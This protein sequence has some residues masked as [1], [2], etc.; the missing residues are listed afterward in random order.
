LLENS[1]YR[2]NWSIENPHIG[3]FAY[4]STTPNSE[5]KFSESYKIHFVGLVEKEQICFIEKFLNSLLK[6]YLS[7]FLAMLSRH[8][9]IVQYG[10]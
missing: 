5:T 2:P 10:S 7:K 6:L 3:S 1:P 8:S 9:A 4:D